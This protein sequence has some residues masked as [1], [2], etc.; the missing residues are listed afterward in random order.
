MHEFETKTVKFVKKHSLIQPG[1]YILVAV[2]GGP[3]SMALLHFLTKKQKQLGITIACVHVDHMLRGSESLDDLEYVKAYCD[4][5]HIIFKAK[6]INIK[7]KMKQD[8]TGV[9]LAAR[10]YRYQYFKE[11]M[12]EL[13]ANKLAVAQHAD[14]QIETILMRLTRGS[15]G[16]ARAGIQTKRPFGNGELIR[17]LLAITKDMIEQYCKEKKLDPR[18]DPSNQKHL[19]T[20][21]RFRMKVIPFLKRENHQVEV[22]FQRFSEELT[23]DEQYLQTLAKE[24][25]KEIC[26]KFDDKDIVLKIPAFNSMPLPLQRRGIHLILNYLYQHKV[27]DLSAHHFDAINKLLKGFNPSGQLN[28]PSGLKVIRTYEQCT[29]TFKKR[30]IQP[31]YSFTLSVGEVLTLPNQMT[32]RFEENR[33]DCLK[34]GENQLVINPDDIELPL[35]IR[36]RKP[37]DRIRVKGMEGSKKLKN[38]FIDMKVDVHERAGWPIVTDTQGKILW[39][40]GLKK[41]CYDISPDKESFYYNIFFNYNETFSGRK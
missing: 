35:I 22:H 15:S 25:M 37:G 27:P 17:P 30:E 2:S 36:T 41:S 18:H 4:L 40:P 29:F 1:D 13:G 34:K 10:T 32:F 7:E 21:N 23:E 31:G 12:A 28:L 9:Q 38:L 16:M 3:D 39:I 8:K 14:D 33:G 26:Q 11:V 6:S 5:H 20:R 19:Y 24:Q